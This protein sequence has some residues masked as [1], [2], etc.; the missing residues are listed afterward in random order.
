MNSMDALVLQSTQNYTYHTRKAQITLNH[1]FNSRHLL[2][3]G[4]AYSD[5]HF[6]LFRD[7]F[8]KEDSTMVRLVDQ[9]GNTGYLQAYGSWRYRVLK[10]LTVNVGLH[11]MRFSLNGNHSLEPRMGMKWQFSPNQSLSAGFGIH[12]K[13]ETL[14]NYFTEVIEEDDAISYPNKDL[15]LSKARHY[16]LAYQNNRIRNLMIKTEL[17]YQYLYDILVAKDTLN[18]FSALNSSW[19]VTRQA[20]VNKGTGTN[21]G[22]ELTVEKFF[23]NSWYCLATTSLYQ[24][25]YKGSD[26]IQRNTRFNG[27]YVFNALGGKEFTLGKGIYP[28]KLN[29]SLRFT[30]A[31]GRRKIPIDLEASREAGHTIRNNEMAYSES[32]DDVL[33]LDCK[34]SFVKNR[35]RS[36][37]TIEFDFLNATNQLNTIHDYYN[38]E[39]DIIG[40]VTQLGFLPGILYRFDF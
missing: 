13:L 16:V 18:S 1:K 20:L 30:Y 36:T 11:Y 2:K 10:S 22:L 33:R 34:V 25:M 35:A 9:N 23:S 8:S 39:E 17:Y 7:Y 28:W 32:Y 5:I 3:S 4:L 38:S 6:D 15:E 27:N 40:T 14:T 12:S 26:M 19:G 24:S 21:Y 29:T 31:G 37:H